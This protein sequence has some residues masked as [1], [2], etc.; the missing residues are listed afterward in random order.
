[1]KFLMNIENGTTNIKKMGVI[2]ALLVMLLATLLEWFGQVPEEILKLFSGKFDKVVPYVIL[3]FGILVKFYVIIILLKCVSDKSNEQKH[4]YHLDIRSFA[5]VA[6]MIIALRMVFDNSLTLWISK[7]SMPDFINVAFEEISISPI[8]FIINVIVVAPIYEEIIFRGILL[9]G[10]SKKINPTAAIVVSALLF[11]LVHLNIPQG[12][13][14]FLLGLA[15]G[16]IYL[17]TESIYLSIFAHFVNNFLALSVSSMF[18]LIQGRY[19]MEIHG[20]FFIVGVILL[21][22]VYKEYNQNKI[23]DVPEIYKQFIEI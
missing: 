10:M 1:M 23:I 11:A 15:I 8:I 13:N 5:Y 20:M 17:R 4:K 2:K 9:K 16:F 6:L 19:A 3:T 14:A 7:I 18:G 12:I 22:L 21:I